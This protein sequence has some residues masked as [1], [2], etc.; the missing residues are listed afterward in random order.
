MTIDEPKLFD[1]E[2]HA[3]HVEFVWMIPIDDVPID[4]L[5][6]ESLHFLIMLPYYSYYYSMS[7][8][9]DVDDPI[10]LSFFFDDDFH[11]TLLLPTTIILYY[12]R[13]GLDWIG[14][15]LMFDKN[16]VR[17]QWKRKRFHGSFYYCGGTVV[18]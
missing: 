15:D 9:F 18:K 3:I 4:E 5:L 2:I 10:N 14:L 16:S 13:I 12:Y 17:C 6:F 8:S 1:N 7:S 11:Q